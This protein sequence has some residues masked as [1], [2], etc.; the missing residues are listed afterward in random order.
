VGV[1]LT[2]ES[3]E[4]FVHARMAMPLSIAEIAYQAIQ[5]VI[6]NSDLIPSWTEE[7]DQFPGP[8]WAQ[9]SSTSLNFLDIVLPSNEAIIEAMTGPE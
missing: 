9:N 1:T 8:I 4:G 5:Q 2:C 3:I 6:A 7:E